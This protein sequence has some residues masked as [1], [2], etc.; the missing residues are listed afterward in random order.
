MSQHEKTCTKCNQT[1]PIEAFWKLCTTK[2]GYNHR[3]VKCCRAH[4]QARIGGIRANRRAW[5]RRVR[6]EVLKHY[7]GQC[8]CCKEATYEFLAIDHINGGGRKH[9]TEINTP[10]PY[11]LKKNGFP[12]GFRILCHNCNLAKGRYGYCPHEP[13]I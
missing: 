4:K 1:K 5:E 3:C 2:D 13:V 11:W 7:G 9:R 10:L 12:E 6:E 8:A